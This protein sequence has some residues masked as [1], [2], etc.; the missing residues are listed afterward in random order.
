MNV[1]ASGVQE[2]IRC[3]HVSVIYATIPFVAA[4]L[5]RL[6]LGESIRRRTLNAAAVSLAGVGLS[7]SPTPD[8]I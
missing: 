1:K 3:E 4:L 5:E 8:R 7:C 6:I 2:H